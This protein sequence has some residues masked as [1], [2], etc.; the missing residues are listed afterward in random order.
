MQAF[1]KTLILFCFIVQ[2]HQSYAQNFPAEHWKKVEHPVFYGWDAGKLNAIEEY[3]ID[4]TA[5]TAMMII[6]NGKLVYEYGAI[7]ENSYIA[8]CRKSIL[9][10]LYGKHVENGSIQLDKSLKD[11]GITYDGLLL[12]NEKKATVKDIISSRSGVYL[13]ASNP[14]DMIHLAPK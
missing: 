3:V 13:P 1:L 7:S 4:S 10:M 12:E 11:L 14:G 8:S 6:Q 2:L 5:T 9:A